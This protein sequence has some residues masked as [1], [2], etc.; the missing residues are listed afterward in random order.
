M[1]MDALAPR[2]ENASI[3]TKMTKHPIHRLAFL[4]SGVMHIASINPD[5][6]PIPRM[7]PLD[8]AL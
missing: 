8:T 5:T 4:S 2:F 3:R 1:P 6:R 7:R